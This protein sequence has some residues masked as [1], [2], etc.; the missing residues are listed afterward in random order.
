VLTASSAT[1]VTVA[2]NAGISLTM[3]GS[4]KVTSINASAATG[5]VTV[6]SLNTTSATTITGGSG[7]DVLQAA[8]GTTADVL[9][10]GAGEDTLTTN[11][12]LTTLTGGAG[13]DLFVIGVPSLSS[14][15]YSTISDFVAGDLIKFTGADSFNSV[16]IVLADTAVF[17]DYA[18]AAV[19]AVGADDLA[20]FQY[21]GNTY[22]VMDEG[23]TGAD[24]TTFINGEDFIVRLTGLVDLT[25][26]SFN[27]T[28]D[29]IAL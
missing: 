29:T 21:N 9:I 26:A 15:S 22:I 6:T 7:N 24:S 13:N 20:W 25:S 16:A 11:K 14:S 4:T 8:T 3:T 27:N 17:Q 5:A 23:T 18:N 28:S 2:G 19:N 12:G 1:A 10:G